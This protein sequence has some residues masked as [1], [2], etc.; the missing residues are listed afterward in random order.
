MH[1]GEE[2]D[3]LL[4]SAIA[5]H[6][7]GQ[8][9]EAESLYAEVLRQDSRQPDALNLMAVLAA[10]HGRTEQALELIRAAIVEQPENHHFRFNHAHILELSGHPSAA[11]AYRESL[12]IDPYHVPALINLGNLLLS[13]DRVGEAIDCFNRAISVD[14]TVAQ[15]HEGLGVALQRRRDAAGALAAFERAL[16]IDPT[17]LEA[18]AN[19][20][21]LLLEL[22]RAAEAVP[23]LRRA[24]AQAPDR[25]DLHVNLALAQRAAEDLPGAIETLRGVQAMDPGNPRP[26]AFLGPMLAEAGDATAAAEI[27]DYDR[28]LSRRRL[29]SV[30]GYAA[31]QAFNAALAAM[32]ASHPGLTGAQQPMQS[33]ALAGEAEGALQTLVGTVEAEVDAYFAA[34]DPKGAVSPLRPAARRLALTG[35]ISSGGQAEE[36]GFAAGGRLSGLY[37]VAAPTPGDEQATPASVSFGPSPLRFPAADMPRRR[38]EAKPGDLLL[39]PAYF[40]TALQ[41]ASGEA[42]TLVIAFDVISEPQ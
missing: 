37:I 1:V 33:D 8:L 16:M 2:I 23:Q 21:A 38:L 28:L 12:T 9:A 3:R 29:S 5:R 24:L 10:Q 18:T 31:L 15:A 32:M 19:A 7:A 34:L 30:P 27:L 20:G 17:S 11:A 42:E 41:P 36:P 35:R 14:R 26:L 25:S 13:S 40:W 39:F 22:G 4:T 6:Q